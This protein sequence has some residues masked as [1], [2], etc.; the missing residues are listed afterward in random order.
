M[1]H[2]ES[3]RPTPLDGL[4]V[5]QNRE[6]LANVG[7][8]YENIA[9]LVRQKVEL[10][11]EP[12]ENFT[13]QVRAAEDAM[14]S[15]DRVSSRWQYERSGEERSLPLFHSNN[16]LKLDL[17]VSAGISKAV[18]TI[19]RRVTAASA[20]GTKANAVTALLSIGDFMMNSMEGE[21]AKCIRCDGTSAEVGQAIAHVIALMERR[22]A[23]ELLDEIKPLDSTFEEYGMDELSEVVAELEAAEEGDDDE[24]E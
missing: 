11:N 12:V 13:A 6:I 3:R 19:L 9:T 24:D 1:A 20:N 22:H 10:D 4:N 17:Q 5:A 23:L 8:E 21:F 15:L 2:V 16:D 14:T 18:S 7:G